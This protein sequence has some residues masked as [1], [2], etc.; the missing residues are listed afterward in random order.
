[1]GETATKRWHRLEDT[2][3]L[4]VPILAQFAILF[5]VLSVLASFPTTNMQIFWVTKF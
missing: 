4:V 1:M 5:N 3:F 2:I